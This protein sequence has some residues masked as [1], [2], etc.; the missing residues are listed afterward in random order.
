LN[1]VRFVSVERAEILMEKV[2]INEL[3]P[4]IILW[5]G[6]GQAKVIRPIIEHF[7]GRVVAV[8]D[9]TPNLKPPFPDVDLHFGQDFEKWLK[10]QNPGEIG[11]CITIG[12]PHGRVRLKL[13]DKLV[14]DGLSPVT[15]AHHTAW[16][17]KDA[18]VGA[19]CQILAGA[20]IAAEANLGRQCIVNCNALVEHETVL[21]DA[22]EVAPSA[23]VLGLTHV[24]VNSFIGAGALV[25]SRLK[26]GSDVIIGAGSVVAADVP[27]GETVAD[28]TNRPL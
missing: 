14:G 4:S 2:G 18:T 15:V 21:A 25:L 10:T 27:E 26:I 6:T 20:I 7:G 23:T 5:G 22:V 28:R 9:D 24:G 17:A 16:I 8:F 13:H 3:P 11:F 19:G 1:Q 12:N